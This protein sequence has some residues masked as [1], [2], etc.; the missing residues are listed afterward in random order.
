MGV[1]GYLWVYMS[2]YRC[3]WVFGCIWVFM[4]VYGYL[5]VARVS[6]GIG[7]YLN[8]ENIAYF[9]IQGPQKI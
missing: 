6:M 5:W 1:Y 2:S 9:L 8:I 3:F 4:S 7:I